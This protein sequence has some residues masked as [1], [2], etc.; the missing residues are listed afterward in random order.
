MQLESNEAFTL[1]SSGTFTREN[2]SRI[3]LLGHL[4]TEAAPNIET[5]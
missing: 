2:V 4:S 5:R 1:N 3:Q